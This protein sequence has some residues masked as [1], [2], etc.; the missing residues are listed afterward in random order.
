M[1][2]I[3]I[4]V[5]CIALILFGALTLS[6]VSLS[7]TDEISIAWR[8]MEDNS[9]DIARTE[10]TSMGAET[11]NAG[12][13]VELTLENTGETKLRSFEKWDVIIQYHDDPNNDIFIKRVPYAEAAPADNEWTVEGIYMDAGTGTPEVFESGI[14]NPDEEMVIRM[15]LSPTILAGTTNTITVATPNGVSASAIFIGTP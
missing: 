2:T 14:F 11:Q 10:I 1:E 12:A 4:A 13:I 3:L 6:Q 5:V 8:Q 7:S 9:G 15:Q